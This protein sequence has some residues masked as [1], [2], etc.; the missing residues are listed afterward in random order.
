M[1]EKEP[2]EK[3]WMIVT[4]DEYSLPIAV[5]DTLEEL[6]EWAGVKKNTV[7]SDMSK[8]KHGWKKRTRYVMVK[9]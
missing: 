6:C 4:T 7:Y 1:A 9:V 8:A 3:V 5:F 2:T